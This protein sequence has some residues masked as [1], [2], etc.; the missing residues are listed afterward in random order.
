M[1]G[2]HEPVAE[3][4]MIGTRKTNSFEVVTIGQC[5]RFAT[6]Q[7]ERESG[8]VAMQVHVTFLRLS[9]FLCPPSRCTLDFGFIAV[10]EVVFT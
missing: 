3:E 10:K 6:M 9:L 4:M 7:H 1:M 5:S 8:T 2:Y